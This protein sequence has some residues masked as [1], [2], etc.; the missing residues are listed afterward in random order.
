M[1]NIPPDRAA[2]SEIER[3]HGRSFSFLQNPALLRGFS[4][5]AREDRIVTRYVNCITE[6]TNVSI[7]TKSGGGTGICT[8]ET[9]GDN[10]CLAL[11][12]PH[13]KKQYI[14]IISR[15]TETFYKARGPLFG[16]PPEFVSARVPRQSIPRF[17]SSRPL[18]FRA[19]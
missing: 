3:P 7:G 16:H 18:S 4:R 15:E 1:S 13:R 6:R 10:P 2:A 9:S 12:Y 11:S 5:L 17:V 8:P 14:T 19:W